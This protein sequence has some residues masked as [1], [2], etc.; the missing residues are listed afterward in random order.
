MVAGGDDVAAAV[1]V[2]VDDAAA[3]VDVAVAVDIVVGI[4]VCHAG[5]V[6]QCRCCHCGRLVVGGVSVC[7]ACVLR[8][9]HVSCVCVRVCCACG[10]GRA[11]HVAVHC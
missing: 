4:D 10:C 3:D 8:R 7:V 1:G 9:S 5:Y 6:C 11:L 2:D